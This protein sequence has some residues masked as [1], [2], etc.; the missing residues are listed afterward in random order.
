M[1]TETNSAR[2]VIVG[3]GNMASA[4]VRG[5]L[6]AKVVTALEV[7]VC[8]PDEAKRRDFLALGVRATGSHGEA[9]GALRED[10]QV[11]LAVK[12]Q[13]LR[14]VGEQMRVGLAGTGRGVIVISVLAGTPSERVR[15]ALGDGARMPTGEMV[16]VRVVR[17]MPNLA[18][19]IGQS[20]TALCVG[21]GASAGDD[22]FAARL[23]TGIGSLVVRI[24]ESMMDAFTAVAGSGPAYVFYL[25][26]AMMRAAVEL[27]FDEGTADRVVRETVLG[28]ATLLAES[29]E[30][31]SKL[32]AAVTSKGGTTEAATRVMDE[33]GVM[34]AMIAA[35]RAARD[36]GAELSGM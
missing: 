2:L 9:L 25:A 11:L 32:R 24:D 28:A 30:S 21:A 18:A 36:R 10:G 23:C 14:E 27:G 31:P 6:A 3:G 7:V 22:D 5:A 4:I 29:F 16:G 26:E 34:E 13:M 12:P 19:S 1:T 17:A 15:A 20:A 35:L 8:E 33:R